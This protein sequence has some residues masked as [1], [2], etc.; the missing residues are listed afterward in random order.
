M[1]NFLLRTKGPAVRC[2]I[3]LWDISVLLVG[4]FVGGF[5][6]YEYDFFKYNG[7]VVPHR[8]ELDEAVALGGVLLVAALALGARRYR[9]ERRETVRQMATEEYVQTPTFQSALKRLAGGRPAVEPHEKPQ[10]DMK[11]K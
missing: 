1:L 2:R 8:I 3:S 11:P 7:V 5:L 4:L 10:M 6:A 9:A